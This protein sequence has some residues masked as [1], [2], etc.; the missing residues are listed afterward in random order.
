VTWV[1]VVA[2]TTR[3]EVMGTGLIVVVD[4]AI[5]DA[6][7]VEVMAT[8]EVDTGEGMTVGALVVSKVLEPI[9]V[10]ETGVVVALATTEEDTVV[11]NPGV[12]VP[13]GANVE[14]AIGEV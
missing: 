12:V 5:V 13:E 4:T 6:V 2:S 10:E 7:T 3:V 11:P 8:G 1:V 9:T 14:P